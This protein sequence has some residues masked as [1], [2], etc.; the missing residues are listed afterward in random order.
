MA[1]ENTNNNSVPE[2]EVYHDSPY[3][4]TLS[5]FD[6]PLHLLLELVKDKNMDIMDVDLSELADRYLEIINK[7]KERDVDLASE[8]LVMAATLLQIKARS[9]LIEKEEEIQV[10]EED[11]N[12]ILLQMAEYKQFKELTP[13]LREHELSRHDIFIKEPSSTSNFQKEAD[14]T[15]LDG[16]ASPVS[17][18]KTLRMMFERIHAVTLREAKLQTI[19]LTAGEQLEYIR[20]LFRN[21]D[22]VTFEMIFKLPTINHFVITLIALLDLVRKQEVILKQEYEYGPISIERGEAHA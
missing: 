9:L 7:V 12:A 18:I 19:S 4:I 6:G 13:V 1:L 22:N 21:H 8:Y 16:Y 15:V 20:E 14:P 11:K 2:I 5:N 10:L 3:N 17:L